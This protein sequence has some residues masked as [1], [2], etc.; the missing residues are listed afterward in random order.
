MGLMMANAS[1]SGSYAGTEA[2][3]SM[4][5]DSQVRPNKV[6]DP[7][8]IAA[9]RAVPREAFLPASLASRA[10]AD[11][12]TRLGQGRVM[13]SPMVTARLLQ[14]AGL[15]RGERVLLVAA[16]TG[17]TAALLSAC[18]MD[19]TALE[20]DEALL[21]IAGPALAAWAP[22]VKLVRGP[23]LAGWAEAAPYDLVMIE[24]AVAELPPAIA[25][26]VNPLGR[27]VMVR[28]AQGEVG[29]AVIGR[30]AGAAM[31]FA[32]EFDCAVQPLPAMAK[33]PAFVF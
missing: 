4:M 25:A 27:L 8:I 17:Y 7:R 26:Q 21:A 6:T 31:S 32:A 10:Y 29:R 20:Q 2:A 11:D 5:V 3:R 15:R 19:V 30:K 33:A 9:M 14:A 28:C 23:L 16:G 24:G 1:D 18:D 13:V 22:S 12:D